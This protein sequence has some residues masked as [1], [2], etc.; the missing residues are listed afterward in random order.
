MQLLRFRVSALSVAGLLVAWLA[1]AAACVAQ[2]GTNVIYSNGPFINLPGG[3]FNGLDASVLQ[4]SLGHATPGY[5][6]SGASTSTAVARVADDFTVPDGQMWYVESVKVWCYRPGTGAIPVFDDA[7]ARVWDANPSGPANIVFGDVTTNRIVSSTSANAYRVLEGALQEVSRPIVEVEIRIGRLFLAG[8]YWI[9]WGV[10]RIAT[11]S[12][13]MFAPPI[14]INGVSNTGNAVQF[15][16][17]AWAPLLMNT[18][19]GPG[20]ATSG[21]PFDLCGTVACCWEPN[22]GTNL[23]HGDESLT[24]NL[25]LP[26]AFPLP[27]ALPGGATT[28]TISICSN[29]YVNLNNALGSDFTPTVTEFLNQQPRIGVPWGDYNPA[30]GGSVWFNNTNGRAVA[31]WLRIDTFGGAITQS[32]LQLQ[33]FPSGAFTINTW[34]HEPVSQ[35]DAIF[36][37]SA[38]F[39]ASSTA[40]DYTAGHTGS[41][42]TATIYQQFASGTSDLSGNMFCFQPIH[43]GVAGSYDVSVF[44]ACSTFATSSL[45]GAGCSGMTTVVTENAIAGAAAVL[46]STLPPSTVFQ[47][48]AIGF[49]PVPQFLDLG[50]LGAI[51]C[52]LHHTYDVDVP[53]T[54]AG[55]ATI[56]L[57]CRASLIGATFAAQGGAIVPGVN[58]ANLVTGDCWAMTIGN[59]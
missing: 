46:T 58:P 57:P 48:M 47:I 45:V 10:N 27:G 52:F 26:F 3:G 14:T 38:G 24:P 15:A 37:V 25:S 54:A 39:G 19:A 31:T 4:T 1:P 12:S 56:P 51:G 6:M 20:T 43:N 28:N 29:G 40:I 5:G 36:G 17:G 9:E 2:S 30:T 32:M 41:P 21:M 18:L 50:P 22:L 53:M 34:H 42:G 55:V 8:T 11:P 35:W 13:F 49:T 16:L 59:N 7:V 44:P 33:M 23:A